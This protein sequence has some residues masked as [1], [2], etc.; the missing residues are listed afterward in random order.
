[1]IHQ[2]YKRN[3]GKNISTTTTLPPNMFRGAKNRDTIVIFVFD[4]SSDVATHSVI[5]LVPK[6]KE[7]ACYIWNTKYREQFRPDAMISSTGAIERRPPLQ[8]LTVGIGK[9]LTSCRVRNQLEKECTKMQIPLSPHDIAEM[10]TVINLINRDN[11]VV[12]NDEEDRKAC[13]ATIAKAL[14]GL[15]ES[16]ITIQ[17]DG[18]CSEEGP[19]GGCC[20]IS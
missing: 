19:K 17:P 7:Q 13:S 9:S 12:L 14:Q 8:I 16:A 4:E 15:H 6:A 10:K 3:V 2:I 5:E 20:L 1:M 11:I 18:R